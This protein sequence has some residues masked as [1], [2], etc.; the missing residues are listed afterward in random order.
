M[1][2]CAVRLFPSAMSRAKDN[3]ARSDVLAWGD[4][5]SRGFLLLLN[6]GSLPLQYGSS[7]QNTLR[8]IVW[9]TV[10][11]VVFAL[12]CCRRKALNS[13]VGPCILGNKKENSPS[14]VHLEVF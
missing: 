13:S 7:K 10:G 8:R 6:A 4:A 5:L 3:T 14:R 1:P 11:K 9:L 2:P 12:G